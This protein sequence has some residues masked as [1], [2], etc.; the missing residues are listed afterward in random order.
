MKWYKTYD[1]DEIIIIIIITQ[2]LAH[3][4]MERD[5]EF[6]DGLWVAMSHGLD[7]HTA[8]HTRYGY[9]PL[10][11]GVSGVS[12]CVRDSVARPVRQGERMNVS[13]CLS[14]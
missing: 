9:R 6:E 1:D 11:E 3:T 7:V 2:P 5:R 8:V 4:S 14:Q 13:N 10:S 12:Q